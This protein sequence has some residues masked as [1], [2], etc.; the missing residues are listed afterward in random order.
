M[1]PYNPPFTSTLRCHCC[2][3]SYYEATQFQRWAEGNAG[4]EQAEEW[5][6]VVAKNKKAGALTIMVALQLV[7]ESNERETTCLL[8]TIPTIHGYACASFRVP[9]WFHSPY[10]CIFDFY[11]PV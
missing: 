6:A 11:F 5:M 4:E 7:G 8:K 2:Q 3:A 9:R 10:C 1:F